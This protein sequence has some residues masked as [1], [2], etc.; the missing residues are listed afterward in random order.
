MGTN[1]KEAVKKSWDWLWRSE[2]ILSYVVFLAIIFI[3]IKIIFF[4]ALALIFGSPLPLAI[5]ESSS[6]DHSYLDEGLGYY[7]ICGKLNSGKESLNKDE[8]WNTCGEWYE[9]NTNITKEQF[10]NFG[11]KNGFKKGDLMIIFGKKNPKIGDVI[12]F[13]AGRNHPIIHRIISLNPIQTKGDHNPAQLSIETNIKDEKVLGVAVGKVPYI[14]WVK[15]WAV[16][17]WNKLASIFR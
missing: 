14:G 6:M 2:S 4:P 15:L 12:V 11:F 1:I 10:V 8:Y 3:I 16:E 13:D 17:G 9:K 5:V 7:T